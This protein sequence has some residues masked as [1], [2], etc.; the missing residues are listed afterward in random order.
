MA[1]RTER[2]RTE[3]QQEAQRHRAATKSGP[4]HTFT[5]RPD[6]ASPSEAETS[7]NEAA[8]IAKNGAY[9]L[10]VS[11]GQRP[12]RKSTRR[13]PSHQKNDS[14]LRLKAVRKNSSPKT[15]ASR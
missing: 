10:E 14:T 5:K 9:E 1:T 6:P 3:Q 15:R 11:P 8:R 4:Q 2:F 13:S 7:H 12:P